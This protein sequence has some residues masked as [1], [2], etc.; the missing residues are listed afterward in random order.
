M[1]KTG[2]QKEDI[3]SFFQGRKKTLPAFSFRSKVRLPR[4]IQRANSER[5]R[6]CIVTPDLIGPVRNGGIGTSCSYLAQELAEAGHQVS[7]FFTQGN[8][9]AKATDAW[10][11]PYSQRNI[12]IAIACEWAA[13]R[14]FPPTFPEY[15]PLLMAHIVHD[16]LAERHFDVVVFMEWQGNGYY[17]LRSRQCGLRFQDTVFITHMH[18]PSLWHSVYNAELPEHPLQALT[19]FME[20]QSLALADVVISPSAFMIEWVQKHGY[21]LPALT[22]VQPNLFTSES[23]SCSKKKALSC[24]REFVFFGR[25]EYRKGLVEFCDALDLMVRDATPLPEQVTFLGKFARVGQEHAALYLARRAYAWPMPISFITCAD[26]KE[27]LNYLGEGNRLAVMPS[28]ADNSPYTVYECLAGGIPFIARNTGG[29]AE[30]IAPLDRESCL[31]G[32]NPRSLA[33]KLALALEQ[34][35]RC[36]KLAFDLEENRQAWKALFCS[37]VRSARQQRPSSSLSILPTISVCLTHYS[38]PHLLRQALQSLFEQDYPNFEVILADDGSP[39]AASKALLNALEPEFRKRRWTILR[40]MNGYLGKARNAAAQK[41]SGEFLLFM[42]DDNVARPFMLNRFAQAAAHS[43]ADIITAMFDVFSGNRKPGPRTPVKERF[44]PVGG[45]LSY[46]AITNVI[47][48]ANALVRRTLFLRLGGFSE[49]YGLGHE[50][51]EFFLQATLKGASLAVI[52]ESLFWYRRDAPSMLGTTNT[53]ANRMRSLRPFVDSLAPD[54]TEMVLMTHGLG[55]R[56]LAMEERRGCAPIHLSPEAKQLF[57]YRDPNDPEAL[58]DVVEALLLSKQETLAL[59]ILRQI[60]ASEKNA[61]VTRQTGALLCAKA[62]EKIGNGDWASLRALVEQADRQNLSVR[63]DF[64]ISVLEMLLRVPLPKS[65]TAS[66]RTELC[67]RLLALPHL[68]ERSWLTAAEVYL[69]DQQVKEAV[70]LLEFALR[71][72]DRVYLEQRPDVAQAVREG[73]FTSGLHHYVLHGRFEG[74]SWPR[75]ASFISLLQQSKQFFLHN[76]EK[77]QSPLLQY[78]VQAFLSPSVITAAKKEQRK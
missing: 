78:A 32:D 10:V 50:D 2:Q 30:L 39:D 62:H 6:V 42:D 18:S 24:I 33:D 70:P 72:T 46:S 36:P 48:D 25:L 28:V 31:C 69:Q 22:C 45:I 8:S 76:A 35:M 77:P 11:E 43:R 73:M 53:A 57:A 71:Q 59:Q 58:L 68:D 47:G 1:K 54:W 55:V 41:A 61:S 44:L 67:H 56:E 3:L 4:V 65:E 16:W 9:S 17:A 7:I 75:A 14:R 5:W 40:L 15:P 19:W 38:R 20:R 21:R 26:H 12:R 13:M 51:F 64:Y 74:A 60:E 37:L 23:P 29:V 66:L 34:G 49:D 27:A 63:T 52:P